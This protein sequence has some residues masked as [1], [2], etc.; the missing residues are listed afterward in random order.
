MTNFFTEKGGGMLWM[1]KERYIKF[2]ARIKK[3]RSKEQ[4]KA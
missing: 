2:I 3:I 1:K 4:H